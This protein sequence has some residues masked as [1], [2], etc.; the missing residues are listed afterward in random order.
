MAYKDDEIDEIF[1]EICVKISINGMALR[2]VLKLD[3][4]PSP[5]TFY[6]WLSK[7]ENKTKQYARACEERA[8]IIFEEMLEIADNTETGTTTKESEKGIEVTTADM[9]QHR[10]LKVDTRKWMLSKINPKK[11]SDKLQV[12]NTEFKEQPLFPD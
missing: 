3:N 2:N 4:M 10:K 1:N 12:D 11:Y 5:E 6:K 8:E 9:I 7:D